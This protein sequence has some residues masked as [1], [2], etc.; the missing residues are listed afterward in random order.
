MEQ[1]RTTKPTAW[2]GGVQTPV[3]ERHWSSSVWLSFSL[4]SADFLASDFLRD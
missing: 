3:N 2:R 4:S 1:R